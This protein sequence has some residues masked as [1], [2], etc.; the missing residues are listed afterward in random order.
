MYMH[1]GHT[2]TLLGKYSII[3]I[4]FNSSSS[5]V[6]E[7]TVERRSFFLTGGR[8]KRGC[9]LVTMTQPKNV[10]LKLLRGIGVHDI[11]DL[12]AY[13]TSVPK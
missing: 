9:P 6:F 4:L 8:D 10:E 3:S 11:I 5:L 2:S 13:F 1:V 12:L 7:Y